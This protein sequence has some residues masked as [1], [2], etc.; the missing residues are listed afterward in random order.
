M[1]AMLHGFLFPPSHSKLQQLI[2]N[3]AI[4]TSVREVVDV[5]VFDRSTVLAEIYTMW[6]G[7]PMHLIY[8]TGFMLV[9]YQQRSWG[10]TLNTKSKYDSL[11]ENSS[12]IR[13]MVRSS[14]FVVLFLFTK[15]VENAI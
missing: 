9:L 5:E 12:R 15:N 14:V 1:L 8:F 4:L 10:Q 3:Q 13:K 7:I 11:L 6:D 2:M